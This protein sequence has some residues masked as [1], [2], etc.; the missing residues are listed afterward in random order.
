MYCLSAIERESVELFPEILPEI[1]FIQ[2]SC[3]LQ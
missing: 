2:A 3:Q 1:S